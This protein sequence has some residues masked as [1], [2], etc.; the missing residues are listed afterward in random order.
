M[1]AD[2][3]HM[4]NLTAGA[5]DYSFSPAWSPDG[6]KIAFA[7][8]SHEESENS[9]IWVMNSDGTCPVQITHDPGQDKSPDWF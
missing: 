3:T 2:G 1:N 4:R 5:T 7:R 9:G 8:M 6:G